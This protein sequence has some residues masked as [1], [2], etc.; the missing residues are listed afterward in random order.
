MNGIYQYH[1]E[2]QVYLWR[3]LN[4]KN[5]PGFHM[6]WAGV[7]QKNFIEFLNLLARIESAT[8]RTL[9]LFKPTADVLRVPNNKNSKIIHFNKLKIEIDSACEWSFDVVENGVYLKLS[10][11]SCLKLASICEQVSSQIELHHKELSFWW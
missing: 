10:P 3:Y 2:G 11:E 9:N 6:A 8:Y 4:E 5:Y 7:G 1:Q